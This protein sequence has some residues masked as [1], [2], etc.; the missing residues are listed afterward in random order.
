M[1]RKAKNEKAEG[2]HVNRKDCQVCTTSNDSSGVMICASDGLWV[3]C[4]MICASDV[5]QIFSVIVCYSDVWV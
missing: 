1:I 3:F 2:F 5:L 4:V